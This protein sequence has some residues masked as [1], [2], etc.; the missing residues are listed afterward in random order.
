MY[1]NEEVEYL[2]EKY[3][4]TPGS[5][6]V[7]A[8][9]LNKTPRSIISKLSRMGIYQKKEYVSKTGEKPVTKLELVA[10][11]AEA[12]SCQPNELEGLDKTP[13]EVLR[14]MLKCLG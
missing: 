9:E 13:K 11:I 4:G 8:K 5:V 14:R 1:T 10:Q 2:T 3:D 12:L 7:L 6:H